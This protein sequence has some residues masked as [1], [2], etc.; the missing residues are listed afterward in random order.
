MP[1]QTRPH[2]RIRSRVRRVSRGGLVHVRLVVAAIAFLGLSLVS[3]ESV[4]GFGPSEEQLLAVDYT[5]LDRDDWPVSTPEAVGLDPLDVARL[6]YDA[7]QLETIYGLLVVKDGMLVAE[8]YWHGS[9]SWDKTHLQSVTKSITGALVGIALEQGYIVSLDQKMMDYFPELVGD[10]TDQRKMDITIR[11]LLQMRAGYPWEESAP[12]LYNLLY[13]EGLHVA[14]LVNV[15]L[16]REPGTGHDYSNLSSHLLGI[17]VSR[18]TGMDLQDY[19]QQ[20][21][22]D[23]IDVVSEDWMWMWDDYRAGF[24][25]VQITGREM[26]R[27]GQLYLDGGMFGGQQVVPAA[28]VEDSLKTYSE[29]AW[30]YR[31][32][33]NVDDMGY[34]YQWWSVRSGAHQYNMAWGHGGQL[35]MVVQDLDMVVVLKAD[36]Y[37]QESSHETWKNERANINLVAD[38]IAGLPVQ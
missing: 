32:G 33:G 22:F 10:I 13:Y 27:F 14:D 25:G 12:E 11:H 5:T 23:G 31:I 37:M 29:D 4:F 15:P 3:C 6:Y 1:N 38:F 35:I 9:G 19:A 2:G 26:A 21:L 34:G 16:V 18:A 17:I 28:W 36:P 30:D 8:D 7:A 24:I 20:N